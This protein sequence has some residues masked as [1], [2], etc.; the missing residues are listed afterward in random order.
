MS[1]RWIFVLVDKLPAII[2]AV[3]SIVFQRIE[4]QKKMLVV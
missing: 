2:E 1:K 4:A 3:I